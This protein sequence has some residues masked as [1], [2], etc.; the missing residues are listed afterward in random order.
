MAGYT[1][2]RDTL[3]P[4]LRS[5]AAGQAVLLGP[6]S[7]ETLIVYDRY[8]AWEIEDREDAALER[9]L[10]D[11]TLGILEK[12]AC[13]ADQRLIVVP[14]SAGLDSRLIASGLKHLGYTNVRC[15]SY[16]IPGN[17]EAEAARQIAEKLDYPWRFVPYTVP[18]MKAFFASEDHAAYLSFADSCTSVPFEQDLP[19]IRVLQRDGYIPP[20]GILVNGNSG[21]FISGN[22]IL[23]RL[24]QPVTDLSP[25][26]RR[27]LVLE[28]MVRKHFRLWGALATPDNDDLVRTRLEREIDAAG[29]VFEDPAAVHGVFE[30]LE[31]QDRQSKYVISGQ[32]I[33]EYAGHDWRLPLWDCAY[34]DFWRTV[35]LRAKAG[36]SLYRAML[37]GRNWA[38]VWQ[39]REWQFPQT[40]VPAWLRLPRLALKALHAPL[41]REAWHQFERRYLRYWMGNLMGSTI[42]PYLHVASDRRG[43]RHGLAWLDEAYLRRKGLDWDGRML[44]DFRA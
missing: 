19:A 34:L 32:R 41:G 14:L 36:Q 20:D 28:T 31:H 39:G 44:S 18:G 35:P 37:H 9:Q 5:L 6:G 13:S 11:V 12:M 24:R 23:G 4:A 30:Y 40:V 10:A 3:Y 16:G 26:Q 33:Y 7:E 17:H 1:I 15:F 25:E 43:A 2:G 38:G 27:K 22:H 29:A 42:H 21:D 8:S